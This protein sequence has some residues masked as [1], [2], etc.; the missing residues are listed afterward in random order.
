V[1]LGIKRNL[2][3]GWLRGIEDNDVDILK[4]FQESMQVIK[5]QTTTRVVP[6]L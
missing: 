6:T 4:V 2:Y 3:R 1:G 5:V